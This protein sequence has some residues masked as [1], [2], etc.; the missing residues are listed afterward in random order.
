MIS[1]SGASIRRQQ[2]LVW[3]NRRLLPDLA[4]LT[5]KIGREGE[6]NAAHHSYDALLLNHAFFS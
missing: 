5:S 2:Q 4:L 3:R 6:L 1:P